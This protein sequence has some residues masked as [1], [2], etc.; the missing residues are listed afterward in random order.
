M[1]EP[2]FTDVT[3]DDARSVASDL[4]HSSAEI[5][6]DETSGPSRRLVFGIVGTALIMSAIDLT[7]VATALPAIKRGLGASINWAG[8]VI[9]IY[10]LGLAIALPIAGKIS[11]QF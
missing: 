7:I 10:G 6:S 5:S 8:W 2:Q 11:D 4:D 3:R 9:T 1:A